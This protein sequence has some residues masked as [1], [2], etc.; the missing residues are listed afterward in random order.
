MPI[1]H[2]KFSMFKHLSNLSRDLLEAFKQPIKEFTNDDNDKNEDGRR[3]KDYQYRLETIFFNDTIIQVIFTDDGQGYFSEQVKKRH[4][5]TKVI[6]PWSN[7]S[8]LLR[9][10]EFTEAN[11]IE[12][13]INIVGET[14]KI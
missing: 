2:I 1:L 5:L 4:F 12:S 11:C 13:L 3:L 7:L 8:L 9:C 6:T 10:K 14:I